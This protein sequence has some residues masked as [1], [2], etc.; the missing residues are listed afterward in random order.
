MQGKGPRATQGIL[1][2]SVA[3][4]SL[5]IVGSSYKTQDNRDG[6]D[7]ETYENFARQ[8]IRKNQ[9]TDF[10]KEMMDTAFRAAIARMSQSSALTSKS[11]VD[12]VIARVSG[13]RKAAAPVSSLTD[14]RSAWERKAPST[15]RIDDEH[16]KLCILISIF[17]G[18]TVGWFMP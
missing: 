6:W 8:A 12:G 18:F 2:H 7:C 4:L 15:G 17:V 11:K 10:D 9:D 3:G 14:E 5:P 13:P 1:V 16:A